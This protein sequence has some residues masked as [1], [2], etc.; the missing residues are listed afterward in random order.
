[1]KII[2]QRSILNEAVTPALYAVSSKNTNQALD[3]FLLSADRDAGTLT[4]CGYDLEKGVKVTLSGENL[5]IEKGGRIIINASK[6]SSII[7]NLPDGDIT[8]ASD[9]SF[10]VTISGARSEFTVHGLDGENFPL[11]PELKGD[12]NFKI[13]RKILKNMIVSTNFAVAINNARPALNGALF[14]IRDNGFNIIA[15]DGNRLALRRSFDGVISDDENNAGNNNSVDNTETEEDDNIIDNNNKGMSFIIPGRSLSELLKLIGDEEEPAQIALTRKH[16]IISFDNIIFFSRLIE[17]EF[18]DYRRSIKN[19]PKTSVAIDVRSLIES[20]ERASVLA[21]DKQKTL[22]KLN[23]RNEEINIENN[24]NFGRLEISSATSL[25][26]VFDECDIEISGNDIEIGFNH[27]FLLDALKAVREEK[28]LLK[29]ESPTKSMVIL[30]YNNKDGEENK[31]D[32]TDI[33]GMDV[34]NSKF[35]YLVLPVRM[36]D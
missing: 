34:E 23:F 21:D 15:V 26:K 10:A 35:L 16:V 8:I 32:V 7:R 30:P 28:V 19:D 12:R 29:L 18:L 22:V 4:I 17:S 20:V 33:N 27:R 6:F 25:G 14:E 2:C 3:G 5:K 31:T 13:G 1:M 24:D 9:G 11:M 36:R